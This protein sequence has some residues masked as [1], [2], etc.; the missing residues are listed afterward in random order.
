M[1]AK[2]M[3]FHV[4][5]AARTGTSRHRARN[6][7]PP[8]SEFARIKGAVSVKPRSVMNCH[9]RVHSCTVGSRGVGVDVSVCGLPPSAEPLTLFTGKQPTSPFAAKPDVPGREGWATAWKCATSLTGASGSPSSGAALPAH[10]DDCLSVLFVNKSPG[11]ARFSALESQ[12][13]ESVIFLLSP[14]PVSRTAS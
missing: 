2:Y 3:A 4:G 1:Q 12:T 9:N 8:L 5:A 11:V 7:A 13:C 14:C 6:A 10:A